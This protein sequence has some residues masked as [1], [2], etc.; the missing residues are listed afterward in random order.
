MQEKLEKI[1]S[2]WTPYVANIVCKNCCMFQV[3]IK[4]K[5]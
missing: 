3:E 4:K 1:F 5:I 2:E